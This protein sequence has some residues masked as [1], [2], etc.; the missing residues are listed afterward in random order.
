[1]ENYATQFLGKQIE[2]II[3]RP[4]G[5][6]HPKHNYFY[7]YNYGFIP[8]TLAPDMEAVDVYILGVFKPVETFCG[9]CI[10]VIYIDLRTMMISVL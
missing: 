10:A 8:N 1:M 2:V 6:K 5:S 3:D 4:L 7:S 9:K